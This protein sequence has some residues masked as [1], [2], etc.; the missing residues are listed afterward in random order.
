[1]GNLFDLIMFFPYSYLFRQS[2]ET[3]SIDYV[4]GNING[5]LVWNTVYRVGI[6]I[7]GN[8]MDICTPR[9]LSSSSRNI[10]HPS[11]KKVFQ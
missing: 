3:S 2:Q 11:S 5:W 10:L 1:M 7:E 6:G 8:L 9:L 4:N